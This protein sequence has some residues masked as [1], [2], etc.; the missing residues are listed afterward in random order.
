ML[1]RL[2]E[3]KMHLVKWLLAVGWIALILSLFY[4]PITPILTDPSSL[5]S[6]FRIDP[7]AECITVQG[8]CLPNIPYGMAARIFW[9]MIVPAGLVII[10]VF[11]HELWRR[12][13]PLSFFSQIPRALGIQRKGKSNSKPFVIEKDSWLGRNHLYLQF[14]FFFIGLNIRILFVNSDRMALAAFLLFTIASAILVGYLF[15]GKSWC[16]YFCPMA[17]VQIVYTGPRGLLD[18]QS[19][20][21]EHSVITQSM[22]REVDKVTGQDKSACVACQSPCIDIDSERSYWEKIEQS[23]YK[24]LYFGYVGLVIGFYFYYFLYSGNWEY[25]YSG[26]WTHEEGQLGNLFNPGFYLFGQTIAIPKLIATPLA[27]A[28]FCGGAYFIGR[29]SETAYRNHLK[30]IGKKLPNDQI[31]H[32]IFTICTVVAW[33]IFWMFGSRPNLSLLPQ[34][35]ERVFTGFIILVSGLWFAQT[36][37]RTSE[38]YEREGLA[39][40]F[41]RQLEKLG[42]DLSRFM[43][44]GKEKLTPDEAYVLMQAMKMPEINRE[45]RERIYSGVIVEALEKEMIS[46]A[47]EKLLKELRESLGIDIDRHYAILAS[48]GIQD[49]T[50]FSPENLNKLEKGR[51]LESYQKNLEFLI[52]DLIDGGVPIE[53]ALEQKK[54][55]VIA[56]K[57]EYSITEEEDE[58][59]LSKILGKEGNLFRTADLLL[60]ELDTLSLR[61]R[62]LENLP[63]DPGLP[64]YRLLR[65]ILA[66][67]QVLV[68]NNLMSILEL[69]GTSEEALQIAQNISSIAYLPVKKVLEQNNTEDSW[70]ERLDQE[71]IRMLEQDSSATI[72]SPAGTARISTEGLRSL[73][74]QLLQEDIE[75]LVRALSLQALRSLD[76]N[77]ATQAAAELLQKGIDSGSIL[78]EVSDVS[79]QDLDQSMPVENMLSLVAQIYIGNEVR[80][81]TFQKSP[82]RIGRDQ[83]NDIVLPDGR[84]DPQH[85]LIY[86]SADEVT[87]QNLSSLS[88]IYLGNRNISGTKTRLKSGDVIRFSLEASIYITIDLQMLPKQHLEVSGNLTTLDKMLCLFDT[89]LFGQVKTNT[90]VQIARYCQAKIYHD[91]EVLCREGDVSR[92]LFIIIEG[93]VEVVNLLE[94][95]SKQLLNRCT[96]GEVIGE[97]GFLTHKNR[98]ATVIASGAET[99]VLLL[100]RDNFED[101]LKSDPMLAN[102]LLEMI[103][104]RL[105]QILR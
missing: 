12:I 105:Q 52:V 6:P 81:K 33:N 71:V 63:P 5:S 96:C 59:V 15:A 100:R 34:W 13:C 49:P 90:L 103:S 39:N 7:S 101:L 29:I 24:L 67:R 38:G 31:L 87:V 69:L 58:L 27:L 40:N 26:A 77:Q 17:P 99:H 86:F 72:I 70:Q 94:N 8:N 51:R 75:P 46:V 16:Q 62:S 84:I 104:K 82:I 61:H 11:G 76:P 102:S 91:G 83:D 42:I 74:G 28:A 14:G 47:E 37:W 65:Q 18:S 21:V 4:D 36:F 48:L 73:L 64:V 54:D 32:R 35:M 93:W 45:Q 98:S 30:K 80:R 53:E 19:N 9:A 56:L 85:A 2:S 44:R 55:R 22:C 20:L 23:D 50:L 41:R 66:E 95:G 60:E 3:K 79:V 1:S 97:L 25:Y 88:G 78:A 10:F 57:Q 68:I 43:Q 92:D 89:E